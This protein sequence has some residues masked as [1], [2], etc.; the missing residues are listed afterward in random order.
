MDG[1]VGVRFEEAGPIAFCGPGDLDL[2][3]G[4]YVVVRTPLGERLG[5]VVLTPDQVVNDPPEGPVRVVERLASE[6]DVEAHREQRRRAEEDIGRAQG[7]AARTDP[8]VRVASI[9]YDLAGEH[10]ELSFTAGEQ[11]SD[12]A[13]L[14]RAVGEALG[15]TVE[16]RQV[17]DRDRAKALGGLGQCGRALCCATWQTEFPSISI[18]MAKEQGLAPNPSKIS[19]VCGRLLCCLS[20][21]VD[22]YRELVGDLPKVGKR[23]STPVGRARILNIDA[24]RQVVRLRLDGTREIVEIP[25]NDLRRQ[26]GITVRPTDLEDEVEA[27]VHRE[28]RERRDNLVAVLEPVDTPPRA[29]ERPPRRRR[30]ARSVEDA[31]TARRP[32]SQRSRRKPASEGATPENA[33]GDDAPPKNPSNKEQPSEAG[34][35]PRRRRRRGRRGG[36]RR[37]G[38]QGRSKQD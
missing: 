9:V 7:I 11:Y 29:P 13:W 16:V 6:T 26:Y 15:A 34:G 8:R 33:P 31:T 24:M 3:I 20:F 22:A 27:E 10:A 17:G 1:I 37:R 30:R 21:E 18:S 36:R 23:V 4:D 5:W 38:G 19:G 28:D 12:A 35:E 32:G 25:A 2:G 14:A